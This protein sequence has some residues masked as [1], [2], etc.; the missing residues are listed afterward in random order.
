MA[1]VNSQLQDKTK[2][3]AVLNQQILLFMSVAN[4]TSTLLPYEPQGS[5]DE[6]PPIFLKISEAT[7]ELL[8]SSINEQNEQ[9]SISLSISDRTAALKINNY[10]FQGSHYRE[11]GSVQIYSPED[12]SISDRPP[13][14]FRSKGFVQDR[15][16]LKHDKPIKL[17]SSSKELDSNQTTES[18][19]ESK[20]AFSK[21]QST[22]EPPSKTQASSSLNSTSSPPSG[23]GSGE[24]KLKPDSQST[25]LKR[26]PTPSKTETGSNTEAV[27]SDGSNGISKYDG[28]AG[29]PSKD[30]GSGIDN[31]AKRISNGKRN[32]TKAKPSKNN[33]YKPETKREAAEAS[34]KRKLFGDNIDPKRAKLVDASSEDMFELARKFREV[35]D[36]YRE[37]YSK[38]SNPKSRPPSQVQRL[39]TMHR[40]LGQWK[41]T[42]WSNSRSKQVK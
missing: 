4:T 32:G 13:S 22:Y 16:A 11:P 14:I 37:L 41:K 35:Y 34:L 23:E 42:L 5:V 17:P 21:P 9:P 26:H 33:E 1:C 10:E 27:P 2:R 28:I 19:T 3:A 15:V 24:Y 20:T 30:T 38:L 7:L 25:L 40:Q 18:K 8:K 39:M 31:E 12:H 36:E 6:H 29:D